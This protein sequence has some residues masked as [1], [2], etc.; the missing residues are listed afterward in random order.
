MKIK[1]SDGSKGM[2]FMLLT[3]MIWSFSILF[4]KMLTGGYTWSEIISWRF[5]FGLIGF[6]ILI[7]GGVF[8]INFKGKN[9]K[10]LL[11]MTLWHPILYF[12]GETYGIE[13][14][15]ASESGIF[16]AMIPV[17]TLLFAIAI[18]GRKPSLLQ[19]CG[20]FLSIFGVIVML[21]FKG[22]MSYNIKGYL[23]LTL[24]VVSS[25]IYFTLSDNFQLYSATEKSFMVSLSGAIFFSLWTVAEKLINGDSVVE[26]LL[27]PVKNTGFLAGTAYLGFGC[28]LIAYFAVNKAISY[29]GVERST[30]FANITTAMTVV[31]GVYM[32]KESLTHMQILGVIFV[33]LGVYWANKSPRKKESV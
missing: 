9:L 19:V 10:P 6:L 3:Q 31:G 30:S 15:T 29:I 27:L 20:I 21:G 7:G 1:L 11:F 17:V 2:L 33:L 13:K 18:L 8:K 14:T 16:I 25:A 26:W 24:A 23:M 5:N 22:G 28:S 4:T 32:L 12:I